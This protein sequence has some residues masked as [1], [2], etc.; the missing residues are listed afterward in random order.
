VVE[1]GALVGALEVGALEVGALE[2][3]ALE[4]GALEVGAL[5]VGAPDDG[6]DSVRLS[7]G[8]L[9]GLCVGWSLGDPDGWSCLASCVGR[10]RGGDTSWLPVPRRAKTART[11][12]PTRTT[13]VPV[14][15]APRVK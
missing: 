4:V 10:S 3:G 7:D 1:V 5:E 9:V 8:L 12:A 15:A 13:P 11:R 6:P 2:V 14:A